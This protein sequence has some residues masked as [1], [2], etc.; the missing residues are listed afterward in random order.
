MPNRP[1]KKA[2]LKM[3]RPSKTYKVKRLSPT[4]FEVVLREQPKQLPTSSKYPT[5]EANIDRVLTELSARG[6]DHQILSWRQEIEPEKAKNEKRPPRVI[7]LPEAIRDL[8]QA[9]LDD[10]HKDAKE[11]KALLGKLCRSPRRGPT[12]E[13]AW[14]ALAHPPQNPSPE[15]Q[16]YLETYASQLKREQN[17]LGGIA[18]ELI[19]DA[20]SLYNQAEKAQTKTERLRYERQARILDG[21]ATYSEKAMRQPA[22]KNDFKILNK[23]MMRAVRNDLGTQILVSRY[24]YIHQ[25]LGHSDLLYQSRAR[26]GSVVM[27]SASPQEL[28]RDDK[29]VELALQGK[30]TRAIARILANKKNLLPP[31]R[32]WSHMAVWKRL[33]HLRQAV[34]WKWVLQPPP[35]S[36]PQ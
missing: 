21:M 16:A 36:T 31:G 11:A 1:R 33:R 20:R 25:R 24:I 15:L 18:E 10:D 13:E 8:R 28:N 29:I 35:H 9:L 30:S 6:A 23:L 26:L 5:A 27:S 12:L 2:L 32:T 7:A 3:P 22:G 4:A 34:P 14:E 19:R 17:A